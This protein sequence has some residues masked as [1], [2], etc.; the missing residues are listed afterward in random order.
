MVTL[1]Q[2]RESHTTSNT[3]QAM[4]DGEAH[5]DS[6]CTTRRCTLLTAYK[7][8]SRGIHGIRAYG[9]LRSSIP[10][11][12]SHRNVGAISEWSPGYACRHEVLRS[13]GTRGGALP[14][15]GLPGLHHVSA[16]HEGAT[17]LKHLSNTHHPTLLLNKP[18]ERAT[19]TRTAHREARES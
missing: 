16:F 15:V 8:A 1:P 7:S 3:Y 13:N 9:Q 4:S 19:L 6:P 14:S 18:A 17:S 2:A 5:Q 11:T 12:E 10:Y